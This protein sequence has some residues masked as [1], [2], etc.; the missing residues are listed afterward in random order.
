MS[1][2][3]STRPSLLIRIRDAQDREAWEQFVDIYAPLVFGYCR[4]HGLQDAD[5]ADLTQDVLQSV[6]RSIRG[7]E[8]DR[9]RGAFRAWL[10]T[11]TRNAL[12]KHW[13]GVDREP[14][15]TGSS[16][17]QELLEGQPGKT[18]GDATY[19]QQEYERCL[20]RWS[21]KRIA[22]EFRDSTWRAF[23][24]CAV[25]ETPPKQAAEKLGLSLGAVYTAKSRVLKRLR[26]E[27][28]RM[29]KEELVDF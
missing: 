23:W 17:M 16:G 5:A 25:Q 26:E 24:E 20:F 10:L 9:R 14:R 15:A 18:D 22:G 13:A 6:A 19:W 11:I 27:I 1:K 28:E 12:R 7:L 4:K 29:R 3:P 21:A 2:S 8:Y